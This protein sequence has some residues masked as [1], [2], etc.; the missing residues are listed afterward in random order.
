VSG[1]GRRDGTTAARGGHPRA[2]G[3]RHPGDEAPAQAGR[4]T[5]GRSV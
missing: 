5:V 4:S 3:D 2:V 1:R